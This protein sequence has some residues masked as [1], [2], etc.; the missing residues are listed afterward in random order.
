[1]ANSQIDSA[2]WSDL[3]SLGLNDTAASGVMGNMSQ[4][5]GMNPAIAGGGL[6]QWIGS[7]WNAL[8]QYANS[9]GLDPHTEQAQVGY[10]GQE[11]AAGN[12]GITLSGLNSQ[13]SPQ[14]AALYV[15]Q[16][17]ERPAA[18]A[19]N[20]AN[21]E[22]QAVN[23]Y[24]QYSGKT[25][26]GGTLS[27]GSGGIVDTSSNA[28]GASNGSKM[29]PNGSDIIEQI[30]SSLSLQG[31]D[32]THP[33]ASLTQSAGAIAL[34]TVLVLVGLII[35]IFGLVAVVEKVAPGTPPPVPVPV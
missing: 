22:T 31:F 35:L 2:I 23:F 5:S 17:Y 27:S 21:R 18:W 12:E 26:A 6:M 32:I 8:V 3:H 28:G 24:N 16:K 1:M 9:R 14:A 11:L 4:E 10:F 13:A 33:A 7:R 30:D 25:V 20:N 15:S 19:A 29:F 34:R